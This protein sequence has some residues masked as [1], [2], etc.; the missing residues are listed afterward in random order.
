MD[1]LV[2]EKWAYEPFHVISNTSMENG[3]APF[4]HKARPKIDKM[5]NGGQYILAGGLEVDTP[6]K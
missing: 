1:L 4:L 3:Y 6:I 2:G 5:A